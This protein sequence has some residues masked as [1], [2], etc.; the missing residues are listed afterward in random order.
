MRRQAGTWRRYA[1]QTQTQ[2]QTHTQE[3]G[4]SLIQTPGYLPAPSVD[5]EDRVLVA[6]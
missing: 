1:T 4:S 6:G 5:A 3:L 2:T